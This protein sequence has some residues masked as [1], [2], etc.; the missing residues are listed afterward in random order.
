MPYRF[1]QAQRIVSNRGDGYNRDCRLFTNYFPK[2]DKEGRR[3]YRA[4]TFAA[5]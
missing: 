4:R 5:G 3:D 2:P 1:F